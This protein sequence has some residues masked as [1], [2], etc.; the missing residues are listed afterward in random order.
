MILVECPICQGFGCSNCKEVGLVNPSVPRWRYLKSM[1]DFSIR[2]IK[3][4]YLIFV[5]DRFLGKVTK[6][7]KNP[8]GY[9][10]YVADKQFATLLQGARYLYGLCQ[11]ETFTLS[12]QI[13]ADTDIKNWYQPVVV[14]QKGISNWEI[15]AIERY[16]K[17]QKIAA[18]IGG[19]ILPTGKTPPEYSNIF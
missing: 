11:E 9:F 18:E 15:Y 6:R 16:S 3:S 8:S 1:Q 10:W 4:E 14:W 17:A 19:I 5:R 13:Q 12:A 7:K 2:S